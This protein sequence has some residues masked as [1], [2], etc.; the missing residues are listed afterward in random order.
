MNYSEMFKNSFSSVSPVKNDEEL[1]KSVLERTEK[2]ENK[3]KTG[4]KKPVVIAIAAAAVMALGITAAAEFNLAAMFTQSVDNRAEE[5]EKF[6]AANNGYIENWYPEITDINVPV[7]TETA[8]TSAVSHEPEAVKELTIAERITHE[9]NKLI[10]CD[11]FDMQ[12]VGYAYDGYSVQLFMDFVFDKGGKYYNDGALT[13]TDPGSLFVL[14]ADVPSGGS[15]RVLSS[16]DNIISYKAE[17]DFEMCYYEDKSQDM[18]VSVVPYEE[19]INAPDVF[20][21]EEYYFY[22]EKP[23]IDDFIYEKKFDKP[24]ELLG[25]GTATLKKITISPLQI[26]FT[27]TNVNIND[28]IIYRPCYVTMKN[29]EIIDLLNSGGGSIDFN[30]QFNLYISSG[31]LTVLDVNEIKSV[32]I[33]NEIIE[34]E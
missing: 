10:K 7:A 33:Y 27:F 24:F 5:M 12:I 21:D 29:G 1:L 11:G 15:G 6:A 9:Y 31:S 25:Y 34:I 3:K 19:I 26:N 14:W 22:L 18:R 32:Q 17:Y 23:E 30:G 13:V 2:M 16:N 4:L 28:D 8:V 20:D